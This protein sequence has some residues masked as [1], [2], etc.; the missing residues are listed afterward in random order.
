MCK[1][2]VSLLLAVIHGQPGT[3]GRWTILAVR[4]GPDRAVSC[5]NPRL[6]PLSRLQPRKDTPRNL[7]AS[8]LRVGHIDGVQLNHAVALHRAEG[9]PEGPNHCM[10]T[11]P[12]N[13]DKARDHSHC[14]ADAC[15]AIRS[16]LAVYGE[17]EDLTIFRG[18]LHGE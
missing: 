17:G 13:F 15:P 10:I 3:Q 12:G 6:Y 1:E 4:V 16:G 8:C 7:G 11:D 5:S 18:F 14:R 9:V 2:I